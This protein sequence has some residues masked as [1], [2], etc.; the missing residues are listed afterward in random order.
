MTRCLALPFSHRK[1]IC[2]SNFPIECMHWESIHQ[3]FNDFNEFYCHWWLMKHAIVEYLSI[4]SRYL[5]KL[6][7]V[8]FHRFSLF[9]NNEWK[10]AKHLDLVSYIFVW[11][12]IFTQNC[13]KFQIKRHVIY[14]PIISNNLRIH[15]HREVNNIQKSRSDYERFNVEIY[16][17][18]ERSME[19]KHFET[20][21][22]IWSLWQLYCGKLTEWRLNRILFKFTT[23]DKCGASANY[24]QIR[25]FS[26]LFHHLA[27]AS[28]SSVA[29]SLIISRYN[30]IGF[31]LR[32]HEHIFDVNN[33]VLMIVNLL[34]TDT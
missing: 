19:R 20:P 25:L 30:S 22:F 13:F 9:F 27:C 28:F 24:T 29:F 2:V 4:L 32:A 12:W 23:D 31:D 16:T 14:D 7:V 11:R 3:Y 5:M 8:F 1:F 17:E 6:R 15:S 33:S 21:L 26:N 10:L 18:L 34:L